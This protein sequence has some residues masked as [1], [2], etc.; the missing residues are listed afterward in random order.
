MTGPHAF[1]AVFYVGFTALCFLALLQY[2]PQKAGIFVLLFGALLFYE[3]TIRYGRI[4][5]NEVAP[6]VNR[7]AYDLERIQ[8]H[9][10]PGARIYYPQGVHKL[11]EGVA[12][13]AAFYLRGHWVVQHKAQAQYII[14][15][16]ANYNAHSLTPENQGIY[17]F[18]NR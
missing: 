9:V 1:T 2:I 10:K 16:K 4:Q 7:Q 18:E 11:V 3:N 6:L 15:T 13:A 14:T 17:L 5:A 12:C 8:R